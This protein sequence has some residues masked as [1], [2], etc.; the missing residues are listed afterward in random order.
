MNADPIALRVARRH[1]A[2]LVLRTV[3]TTKTRVEYGDGGNIYAFDLAKMLEAQFGYVVR[4]RFRPA[5]SGPTTSIVWEAVTESAHLV[6]GT[7]VLH[8]AVT[9][10]EVLSWAVLTVDP[11]P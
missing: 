7:L 1:R 9:E 11:V 2:A 5:P 8:A 4:L 3:P 6:T 10:G